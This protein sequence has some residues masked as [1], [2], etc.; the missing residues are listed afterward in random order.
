MHTMLTPAPAGRADVPERPR[1]A[2]AASGTSPARS[3]T[4]STTRSATGAP[5]TTRT[6]TA[7]RPRSSR[8][9]RSTRRRRTSCGRG[10]S[11]GCARFNPEMRLV[12]S[13]R[14]PIERAF[15]Q[16]SMGRKQKN[17]YPEF[18]RGDR[19]VR[20]RV[21]ARPGA[22]GGRQWTVHRKSMVIRGLYGAQLERGLAQFDREQLAVPELLR[23]GARL[24][25]RALD[26][27][28]DFL[29]IHR[30]RQYPPLRLN[31]TPEAHEGTPPSEADIE[32]L[33]D[34]LRRRP[35]ALREA[36]RLRRV[37]VADPADRRRGPD[38][39]GAGRQVRPQVRQLMTT[40]DQLPISF[41]IV[42]VQKAA[43]S[44]LHT[45]LVRHRHIARGDA[46]ELH[47]FDDERL[48]WSAPDYSRYAV[49][50]DP[51]AASGS[52]ATRRRRT[53]GGRGA[54][55]AH[56]PLQPRDA[57][58]RELPGPDRA[59][60]LAVVDG[61]APAAVL[62]RLQRVDRDL[63]GPHRCSAGSPR[64]RPRGRCGGRR[65]WSAGLYGEQLRRGLD[66]YDRSQW[67][68]LPFRRFVSQPDEC[69]TRSPAFL[70][71]GPW[72]QYPHPAREPHPAR[73]GRPR[74]RPPTTCAA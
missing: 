70:G 33:V 37:L 15:S 10:R 67:L 39:G 48:D 16:W 21:D 56:A 38:R 26:Q 1:A 51:P 34:P 57:A 49:R 8:R 62:P 71:I 43:T 17:A 69:S 25:R 27:L 54:L 13:F 73:P 2:P 55:R 11:S 60:L 45:M 52:P 63:R 36:L 42:G 61:A 5:R 64:A 44:T 32:K 20:R 46:K 65:W 19:G 31:P 35:R 68:L 6:T 30:F 53:S 23:V 66:V 24:H 72:H 7:A 59:G 74:R 41:A 47:F 50:A 4:S 22:A 18:S 28:T 29:G 3:C 40:T 58:D 9:S 14:D 12:A